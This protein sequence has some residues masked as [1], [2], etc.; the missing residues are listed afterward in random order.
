[1]NRLF[2]AARVPAAGALAATAFALSSLP[3]AQAAA[4]TSTASAACEGQV[5]E[6]PFTRWAD[7][8]NYVLVPNGTVENGTGWNLQ[9]GAARI[10]RNEPFYVHDE[11]DARSLELPAGS[12]ATT[13]PMCVGLE[14][15]TLRLFARNGGSVL[16]SLL[17]E[18]LFEDATGTTR[19]VPIGALLGASSW[20]PTIPLAVLANLRALLPPGD[21]V[22]V[23]FRFTPRGTGNWSIDDVYVDPFRHG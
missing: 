21:H 8:A 7:L 15:P 19:A 14:H 13:A 20:Q 16:S 23:A 4:V 2:R 11:D 22:E 18:V 9:A 5:V 17:V 12:S 1:M 3:A 10:S 6:Q